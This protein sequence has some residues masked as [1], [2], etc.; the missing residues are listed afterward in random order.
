MRATVS[1]TRAGTVDACSRARLA[2]IMGGQI[3]SLPV[4]EGDAVEKGQILL[5]LWNDDLRCRR[6]GS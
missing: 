5:E 3:A 1:N 2:P 4:S 6:T